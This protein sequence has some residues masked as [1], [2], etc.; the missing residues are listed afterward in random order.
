MKFNVICVI[1]VKEKY[2]Y[3]YRYIVLA[4]EPII[5]I[6]ILST[7]ITAPCSKVVG[8]KTTQAK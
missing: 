7:R 6:L 5:L 8:S 2:I 4:I 1:I 3:V